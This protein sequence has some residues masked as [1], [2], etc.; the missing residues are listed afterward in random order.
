MIKKLDKK[1]KIP[2]AKAALLGSLVLVLLLLPLFS[3]NNFQMRMIIMVGIYMVLAM[4]LNLITGYTGQLSLGHAAFYG[5]GAYTSAILSMRFGMSFM[6]TAPIAAILSAFVALLLGIPTLKLQGAY[7]AIVTL[8]FSEIVRII[9]LNWIQLTRGPMGIPGIARPLIFG[10]QISS[11]KDYYY[12]ILALV[13]ITYLSIYRIM[14]SRLGRAFSAIREDELAAQ[15]MGVDTLKYKILSFTI[16]AFFAG[17]AGSFY[18]HYITYIDPQS[19][20]FNESIQIL[21]MVVLGGMGNMWG[22]MV[23]TIILVIAPEMLRFLEDYRMVMYGAVLI[24]MMLTRPQGIL[25]G[26][27]FKLD[28]EEEDHH[29]TARS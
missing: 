15:A 23:G 4:S 11:S 25:G 29:E 3:I 14:H 9:A 1:K 2:K 5:I 8:G 28:R 10:Y 16:A 18:A 27:Q 21:S 12:L 13:V 26:I 19:F 22:A 7:F 6:I 20:T 17:L 24:I